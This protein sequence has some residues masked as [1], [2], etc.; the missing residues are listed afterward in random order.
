MTGEKEMIS[1][2]LIIYSY[3]HK[4]PKDTNIIN[5]NDA[6]FDAET[7]LNNTD[8]ENTILSVIDKAKYS[9]PTSFYG[10][11]TD[12]VAIVKDNLSTGA[13]TLLNV[14]NHPDECFDLCEC[15]RNVLEILPQITNGKVYWELP[16]IAYSGDEQ[17]D[18]IYGNKR[19]TNFYEFLEEVERE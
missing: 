5:F 8:I 15:G 2:S 18:I 14:I 10:R 4:P 17:C 1:L 9:S 12:K 3:E 13:K 7:I 19:Y 11:T 16:V 6:Y